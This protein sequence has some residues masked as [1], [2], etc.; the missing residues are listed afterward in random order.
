MPKK[1]IFVCIFLIGCIVG[2]GILFTVDPSKS[3][4]MPKCPTKLIF[5]IDCP[6]CGFQRAVHALLHGRLKE[7]FMFNP[8][9]YFAMP[10]LLLAIYC[11]FMKDG[12]RKMKLDHFLCSKLMTYGY[13][14][15]FFIWFIV[16][17]IK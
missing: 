13:V 15:V 12:P 10:Y 4:W 17:N 5:G 7:S 1:K 11:K 3:I 6:A 8:F 2:L 16:R 14:T 9:L